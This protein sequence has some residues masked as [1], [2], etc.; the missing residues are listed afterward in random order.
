MD[1]RLV[2]VH[3]PCEGRTVTLGGGRHGFGRESDN[4]VRL[5]EDEAASAHHAELLIR[6]TALVLQDL[7]SHNGTHLN[8]VQ[9]AVP[10]VVALGDVI[11]VGASEWS[12]EQADT[13]DAFDTDGDAGDF[14]LDLSVTHDVVPP[15]LQVV[16]GPRRGEVF[17]LALGLPFV[18]G[19]SPKAEL[20]LDDV[21]VSREHATFF[22]QG[23]DVAVLD[24]DSSNGVFVNGQQVRMLH[25]TD[26]DE[27][28]IGHTILRFLA[29]GSP[30]PELEVSEETPE[31]LPPPPPPPREETEER[32]PRRALPEPFSS[33]PIGK[34]GDYVLHRE[35]GRGGMGR[36][37]SARG[38]GGDPVALK[39]MISKGIDDARIRRRVHR[40]QR[41]VSVLKD[42]RHENV[43]GYRDAGVIDGRPYLAME[44]LHGPDLSDELRHH[45]RLPYAESERILFQLCAAVSAVHAAGIIHRDI[46]PANVLLHGPKRVVKLTD[47]G[48]AR[49]IEE[50]DL[51]GDREQ[52]TVAGEGAITG[53]GRHPGTP[54]YM[55]PEQ[56][57]GEDLDMRSDIWALGVVL[58]QLVSGR[59]PFEGRTGTEV[60]GAVEAACPAA[61]PDDLPGYVRSA[62]YRCLL[63][64]ATWR[65]ASAIELMDALHERRIEQL[66]PLGS[67]PPRSFPLTRCPH[68]SAR[69]AV[70]REKCPICQGDLMLF[71]DGQMM[72][73]E[74]DGK[75]YL[76]CGGC[77]R[78]VELTEP[79][80]IRCGK[81]FVHRRSAAEA[82]HEEVLTEFESEALAVGL[83]KLKRCPLC[84][85]PVGTDKSLCAECG[86]PLR[87]VLLARLVV[88]EAADESRS[89]HCGHC[90]A[91]V[92]S[93]QYA[94]CGA[95]GLEFVSGKLRHGVWHAPAAAFRG[96]PGR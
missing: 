15:R 30:V 89:L 57:R 85:T 9:L 68:C 41:E 71:V 45:G 20:T 16:A 86:L 64:P 52:L 21:F 51:E 49:P 10:T 36:I 65:F 91:E 72:Q 79:V 19:R 29:V 87:A 6:P 38:A 60:M 40:F 82:L 2:C 67:E 83:A 56:V 58:Y 48:I 81:E 43:V 94:R 76:G 25:L 1:V 44:L 31:E 70:G 73:L 14:A 35:I 92:P 75:A 11:R 5:P 24:N 63:K 12:V 61:L 95:C 7:D 34:L 93:G 62:V 88:V 33:A 13:A 66:V 84:S 26:G 69:I 90:R 55:A 59:R 39:I 27:V 4:A 28:R 32:P 78:V 17:E 50:R 54:L 8:G 46:K 3:G 18:V 53:D 22:R 77:A 80:C 74:V 96:R 23:D 37:F 42:V 47:F